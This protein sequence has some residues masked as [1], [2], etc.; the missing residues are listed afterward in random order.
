MQ[1][2]IRNLFQV[3]FVFPGCGLQGGVCIEASRRWGGQ[4][5]VGAHRL[6]ETRPTVGGAGLVTTIC[7]Y[8]GTDAP[9]GDASA[10]DTVLYP[11]PLV[12]VHSRISEQAVEKPNSTGKVRGSVALEHCLRSGHSF[13]RRL[14]QGA[15]GRQPRQKTGSTCAQHAMPAGGRPLQRI[16]IT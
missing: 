14:G 7:S 8:W 2:R 3:E 15:R 10:I 16:V 13:H 9:V 4:G 11:V 6:P 5:A 1:G 12:L